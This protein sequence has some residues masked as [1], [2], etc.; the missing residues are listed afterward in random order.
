MSISYAH[1]MIGAPGTRLSDKDWDIASTRGRDFTSV[2]RALL[3]SR[4]NRNFQNQITSEQ[5]P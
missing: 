1:P 3:A 2:E 4:A 5:P